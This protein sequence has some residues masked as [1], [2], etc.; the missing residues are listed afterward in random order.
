M[1]LCQ[2]VLVSISIFLAI[3][4][5]AISL[6]TLLHEEWINYT[7]KDSTSYGAEKDRHYEFYN[8]SRGLIWI[9]TTADKAVIKHKA[10]E[11]RFGRCFEETFAMTNGTNFETYVTN[12]RRT[13]L[14]LK[15]A[16][17]FCCVIGLLIGFAGLMMWCLRPKVDIPKYR[18]YRGHVVA[19]WMLS[20]LLSSVAMAVYH[21][22]L[23][24]EKYLNLP[25]LQRLYVN[26]SPV[27]K[28]NTTI[29][30]GVMYYLEWACICILVLAA[31]LLRESVT[32][33]PE[34][35]SSGKNASDDRTYLYHSNPMMMQLSSESLPPY[36]AYKTTGSMH[37]PHTDDGHSARSGQSSR[38]PRYAGDTTYDNQAKN[39]YR[40]Y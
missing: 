36:D 1:S 18:H 26:W 22:V 30:W 9:C 21:L 31:F 20:A 38:M 7:V 29:Q 2:R 5:L 10:T 3:A 28:E 6:T 11:V 12:L 39:V 37:P 13:Q 23:D 24:V 19:F 32:C 14:G 15:S 33:F 17:I 25:L 35:E 8:R 4:A 16:G 34:K 27:L 40:I